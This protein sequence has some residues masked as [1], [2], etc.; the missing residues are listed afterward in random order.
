MLAAMSEVSKLIATEWFDQV[1]N[2]QDE[3]AIDRLFHPKGKCY[4]FPD[5]DLSLNS[6]EAF[7]VAH[8]TFVGAFPDIHFDLLDIVAEG[9]HVAI[10]WKATMTHTGDDLG[11]AA[12]GR[13][14][15]LSGS[16]FII[17]SGNQITDGWNHMDLQAMFE[18]LL[19]P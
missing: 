13:R 10:R 17:I 9:D 18:K 11:F 1:W 2:Q 15:S 14:V 5:P 19:A 8:R 3:A 16:S 7:K 12:T 6:P 4:G